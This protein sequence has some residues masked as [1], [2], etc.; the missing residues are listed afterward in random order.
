M[1][2]NSLTGLIYN[3]FKQGN[4]KKRLMSSKQTGALTFSTGSKAWAILF[5]ALAVAF[6]YFMPA[7][8]HML[9]FP[10]YMFEPMRIMLIL[11]LMHTRKQNAYIL[12][13]TLPIVSYLISAHPM[14]IKSLL[15]AI[16]LSVMVFLFYFLVERIH[17]FAAIF[18]SIWLSKLLY[19]GLKYLAI[20]TIMPSEP[21]VGIPLLLQLLTS[22]VFSI[23]VYI[24][25][26]GDG[27]RRA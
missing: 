26:R 3:K 7:I 16:E 4:T 11:A 23:Y 1:P 22:V 25:F 27:A 14:F 9:S 2:N 20:M 13:L 18:A 24:M 12:A 10:V 19:Y 17:R 5:D 15:I 6:I 21:V 8:S